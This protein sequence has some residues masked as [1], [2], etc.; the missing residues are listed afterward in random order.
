[1]FSVGETFSQEDHSETINRDTVGEY[2]DVSVKDVLVM[3]V[4]EPSHHLTVHV[5]VVESYKD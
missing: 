5:C 2:L 3:K 1:M 4:G